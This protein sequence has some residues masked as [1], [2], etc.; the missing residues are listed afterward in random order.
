MGYIPNIFNF[1]VVIYVAIGATSCSYGLAIIGSTVG[2]PS[3]FASLGLEDDPTAPGYHRT[4]NLIGA[5]N[6]MRRALLHAG[7][8]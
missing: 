3:F 5:F 4:A 2:Q 7:L 8:G 6:G 1:W